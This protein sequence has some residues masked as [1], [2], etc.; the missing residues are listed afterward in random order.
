MGTD[1]HILHEEGRHACSLAGR[2]RIRV[3]YTNGDCRPRPPDMNHQ[4]SFQLFLRATFLR[5]LFVKE[6]PPPP[7]PPPIP[8]R[9]LRHS[10]RG[11]PP[12]NGDNLF[13]NLTGE[14]LASLHPIDVK[15]PLVVMREFEGPDSN[16]CMNCR[17]SERAAVEQTNEVTIAATSDSDNN[18][19]DGNF[20]SAQSTNN[21]PVCTKLTHTYCSALKK[22][23]R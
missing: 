7:P 18:H 22:R 16:S 6:S 19:D 14:D 12:A 23:R 4:F 20:F 15:F 10:P 5:T 2:C 21:N 9:L 1:S 8:L 13:C 11:I 17:T 3:L